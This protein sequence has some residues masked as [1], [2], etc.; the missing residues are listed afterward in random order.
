MSKTIGF[1]AIGRNEGVNLERCLGSIVRPDTRVVYVDSGSTDGSVPMAQAMGVEVVQLDMSTPFTAAR[2]RN[3]GFDRLMETHPELEY[4]HFID[5]DCHLAEG[6]LEHAVQAI[7]TNPRLGAVFGRV[8]ELHPERSIYNASCNLEWDTPLG[9]DSP[10][11]GQALMRVAAFRQVGKFNPTVIASEDFELWV[12]FRKAGWETA[13]IAADMSWH[14]ARITRFWQWWKRAERTGHAYGQVPDLHPDSG[15]HND[16]H[17]AQIRSLA[18]GLVLPVI[19]LGLAWPTG[20]WSL[21]GFGLY[22]I[23]AWRAYRYGISRGWPAGPTRGWAMLNAI[24]KFPEAIGVLRWYWRKLTGRQLTL[25][26]Y[27]GPDVRRAA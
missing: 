8:R 2:A 14:D 20:G 22:A 18:W 23:P 16:H 3:V 1:I 13:R 9:G 17:K 26:E 24:A 11:G 25:I 4:V 19:L 12:R 21:L 27:K 7:E 10:F 6:W 15:G 5:G